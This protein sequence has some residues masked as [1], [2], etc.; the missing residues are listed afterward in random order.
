MAIGDLDFP[1][2]RLRFVPVDS[3]ALH[4]HFDRRQVRF[5]EESAVLFDE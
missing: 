5:H 2:P 4:E 3:L 1:R